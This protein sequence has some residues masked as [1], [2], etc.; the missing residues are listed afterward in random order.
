M[1][2][3]SWYSTIIR[4]AV[5]GTSAAAAVHA[6]MPGG[7]AVAGAGKAAADAAAGRG[8]GGSWSCDREEV[9]AIVAGREELA[10][11]REE[12]GAACQAVGAIPVRPSEDQ[13]SSA[14]AESCYDGIAALEES[15]RSMDKY[16][17]GFIG[18]RAEAKSSV[19]QS[20]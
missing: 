5:E 14:C 18:A 1:S 17:S 10:A 6:V 3:E 2:E 16:V 12:D 9:E 7:M 15:N 11:Q 4:E 8:A 13:R 20:G 19:G